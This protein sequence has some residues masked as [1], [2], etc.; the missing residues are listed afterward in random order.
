L[1]VTV[2]YPKDHAYYVQVE[3]IATTAVTGTQ[4]TT[5]S[6]FWLPYAAADFDQQGITPPGP[7]S[8]YGTAS[9]CAN[10]N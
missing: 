10:P 5:A 9:S 1:L 6:T 4:S 8:P 3:L 2:T 7:V